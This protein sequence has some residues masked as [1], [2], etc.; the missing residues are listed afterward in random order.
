MNNFV[1][2][3]TRGLVGLKDLK[4]AVL[5]KFLGLL[6]EGLA[7]GFITGLCLAGLA[8]LIYRSSVHPADGATF[9]SYFL[10]VGGLLGCVA[11]WCCALQFILNRLMDSLVRSVARLVPLT[12]GQVGAEWAGKI[13]RFLTE[14]LRPM[15]A[16]LRRAV[17]FFM[18]ARFARYEKANRAL[19]KAGKKYPERSQDPE[20]LA[21]VALHYFLEPVWAV[22]YGAYVILL[23]IACVFWSLP[24]IR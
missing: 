2:L 22:F 5:K 4:G 8:A 9:S 6:I 21:A 12:T 15:P 19:Q 11:G 1:L 17:E 7:L 14:V 18:L 13:E 24:F 3:T 10:A 16:L 23:L 20:W